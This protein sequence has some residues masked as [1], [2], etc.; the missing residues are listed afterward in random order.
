MSGA[1]SPTLGGPLGDA[2]DDM[3][4]DVAALFRR[5]EKSLKLHGPS[6]AL[7]VLADDGRPYQLT[8]A[9]RTG[10]VVAGL[11][12]MQGA[13]ALERD[14]P[15]LCVNCDDWTAR[16]RLALAAAGAVSVSTAN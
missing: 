3:P 8:R 9:T 16:A 13:I 10:L 6:F 2:L 15:C 4:H 12:L 11:E 7:V 14:D 1:S 5:I